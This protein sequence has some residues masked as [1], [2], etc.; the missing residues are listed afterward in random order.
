[1]IYNIRLVAI[2]AGCRK[3]VNKI[4]GMKSIETL[5]FN[6]SDYGYLVNISRFTMEAT[7]ATHVGFL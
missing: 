3:Y 7:T 4:L 6:D 1:M 2:Q 5:F